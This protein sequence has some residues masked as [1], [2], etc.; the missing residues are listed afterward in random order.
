MSNKLKKKKTAASSHNRQDSV[1]K[2][3]WENMNND[4]SRFMPDFLTRRMPKGKGKVWVVVL[5]T[6]VELLVLGFVG[7]LIYDWVM[8]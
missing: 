4:M 5:V 8:Q 6:L 7:K 2:E 1:F 3:A